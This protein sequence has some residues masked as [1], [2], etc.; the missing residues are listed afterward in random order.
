MTSG[1]RK[2]GG[3]VR[4]VIAVALPMV[5]SLSSDTIMTFTSRW[6]V[7]KLGSSSMNA[8]FAGGLAAFAVQTFF[9]GL[10]GYVTALVAQEFG[11]KRYDHCVLAA[12]QAIL[13]AL[14]AWP[15]LLLF[16][17]ISTQLFGHLGLPAS[18]LPEQVRYFDILVLGSGLGLLRGAFSGFFSGLGRTRIVMVASLTS[19]LANVAFAYVF[20]FGKFGFPA[21]LSQGAALSHILSGAVCVT[22]L[23]ATFL[24]KHGAKSLGVT[25]RFRFDRLLFVKLLRKGTPSGLEFFLNILA[26]QTIVFLFQRQ[27][28]VGATAATIVFNWDMVSF[29]PLVG[30]EIGV[31]SL[32]GRYYGARQFANVRRSLRSGLRLGWAFSSIVFVAFVAFPEPLVDLFQGNPPTLAFVESRSLAIDMIRIASLYVGLEAVMLVF[33]GALR[34]VGDT[35]F[36]MFASTGLHW[37]LVLVLYV[38]LEVAKMP[39]LVGWW[40][41]VLVFFLFPLVLGL[42]WKHATWRNSRA[43]AS[44]Q[45]PREP[46]VPQEYHVDGVAR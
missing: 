24:S 44:S 29:V 13:V 39:P 8:V 28:E 23:G 21:L 14:A 27:G 3:N 4:D 22:I 38:T 11:A 6:F 19:M 36:T 26:F 37:F 18:Q 43:S 16:I 46:V 10:I 33:S 31:T 35:L 2:R 42:R 30:V 20:V 15:F 32:V 25:V 7:S 5:V 41:V 40:I 17:P 12:Y 1:R 9:A 45:I 34:G